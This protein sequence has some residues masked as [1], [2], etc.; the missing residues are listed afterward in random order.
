LFPSKEF[1]RF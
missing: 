1:L